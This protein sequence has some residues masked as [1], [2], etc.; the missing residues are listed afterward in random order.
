[1][2][3]DSVQ[4]GLAVCRDIEAIG[5]QALDHRRVHGVRRTE[6]TKQKRPGLCEAAAAVAPDVLD[7]LDVH[8][9]GG[10][11]LGTFAH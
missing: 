4:I 7:A 5:S 9:D 3:P 11:S 8:V 6:I 1:M 10:A 2:W